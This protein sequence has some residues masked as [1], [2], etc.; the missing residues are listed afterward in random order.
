M[1]CKDADLLFWP[2]LVAFYQR[3]APYS[4]IDF[5]VGGKT[6]TTHGKILKKGVPLLVR[7]GGTSA[8]LQ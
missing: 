3:P 4:S 6:I 1:P 5:T 7:G 8:F 2:V